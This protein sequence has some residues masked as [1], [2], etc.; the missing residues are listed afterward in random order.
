VLDLPQSKEFFAK[1]SFER[2][3][4]SPAE[5]GK[6]IDDDSKHWARL[7]NQVGAKVD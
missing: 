5:F 2:V 6:L 3:T 4:L 7:I 1:N